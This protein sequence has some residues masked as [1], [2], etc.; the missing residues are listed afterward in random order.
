MVETYNPATK[1]SILDRII[2][3]TSVEL[4]DLTA[5][6]VNDDQIRELVNALALTQNTTLVHLDIS[7]CLCSTHTIETLAKFLNSNNTLRRLAVWIHSEN[8]LAYG[9]L[10]HALSINVTLTELSLRENSENDSYARLFLKAIKKRQVNTPCKVYL[11]SRELYAERVD[12]KMSRHLKKELK[13]NL[14]PITQFTILGAEI[15]PYTGQ[16]IADAIVDGSPRI[17]LIFKEV[18]ITTAAALKIAYAMRTTKMI[19]ILRFHLTEQAM[20]EDRAVIQHAFEQAFLSNPLLPR[21]SSWYI[22]GDDHNDFALILIKYAQ[23]F[24]RSFAL[25]ETVFNKD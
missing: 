3:P 19:S 11:G 15:G 24:D 9:I 5:L 21:G 13:T 16:V 22:F 2:N 23:Y 17:G 7:T 4:T 25:L 1:E 14:G 10:A 8:S 18:K 6:F 12:R 20:A